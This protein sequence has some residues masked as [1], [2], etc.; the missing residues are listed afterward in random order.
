MGHQRFAGRVKETTIG[1]AAMLRIDVPPVDQLP[2]FT[3][4]FG[5]H[6][7]YAIT[8]VSEQLACEIAAGLKSQPV[9]VYDLPDELRQRL[10]KPVTAIEHHP[11]ARGDDDHLYED[12]EDDEPF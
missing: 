2:A 3:R 12:P 9:S 10:R 5:A 1:G 6:S 4:Y 7:V 8:P 11:A